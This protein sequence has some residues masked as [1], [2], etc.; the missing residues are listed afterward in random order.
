M[1]LVLAVNGGSSSLKSA[2][3]DVAGDAATRLASENIDNQSGTAEGLIDCLRSI[4]DKTGKHYDLEELVAVGHRVVHGGDTFDAPVVID[5]GVL[6]S[7][8]QLVALAP[9][10]QP[11]NLQLIEAC[12][13]ALPGVPQIACFDTA[14]HRTL[15]ARARTYAL[16][17][18]LT[19]SGL[20][21]YGFH[22][23][24]YE[25]ICSRMRKLDGSVAD[26]RMVVAHLGA[27]ASLCAIRNG[28]SVAT[29]MGFSTAEG[30]PMATRSGSIDPGILIY[31]LRENGM[32]ADDLEQLIYK[33]SGLLGMS[34]IS[35]GM[36][37]LEHS[38]LP[39]AKAAV[40]YFVYRVA[41]EIAS[42]V[43]ALGGIDVLVFTGGVGA[44]SILIRQDV[45]T[46]CGWL[47][48]DI[49]ATANASG[50]NPINVSGSRV[51]VWAVRT[52]EEAQIV[53]H[54]QETLDRT[55]K[56]RGSE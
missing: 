39:Q 54:V 13:K 1:S 25:Y 19:E 30:L 40:D 50:T 35:G 33:E 23:L 5:T 31:L 37:Q 41:Q 44:N 36:R 51:A 56:S 55:A 42:M 53:R 32:T 43:S 15:P 24:S 29:T 9:L 4:L 7:L 21:G 16:P 22:G 28:R 49:D 34:G 52:D 46:A 47:G 14:F 2:L 12:T 3:F 8:Q 45:C 18:A 11:A 20:R 6:R 17:Y 48:I 38:D 10:H 26:K 27:G